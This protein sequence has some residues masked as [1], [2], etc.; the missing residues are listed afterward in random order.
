MHFII[1]CVHSADEQT[2]SPGICRE[3]CWPPCLPQ[4]MLN[5]S[6][7]YSMQK[8]TSSQHEP[9]PASALGH[10]EGTGGRVM[11]QS[12]AGSV[13]ATRDGHQSTSENGPSDMTSSSQV[14]MLTP[15]DWQETQDWRGQKGR[16]LWSR[17][18]RK[19]WRG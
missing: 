2:R 18:W 1:Y 5:Y 19:S 7:T 10:H 6:C 13:D 4:C 12:L 16:K 15:P 8:N 17:G 9:S 11:L 14:W 3:V